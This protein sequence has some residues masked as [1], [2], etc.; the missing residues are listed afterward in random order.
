MLQSALAKYVSKS[1]SSG[2]SDEAIDLVC[3]GWV[4]AHLICGAACFTCGLQLRSIPFV[5]RFAKCLK[6]RLPLLILREEQSHFDF[7]C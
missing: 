6:I 2:C 4:S 5:N 1:I 3:F 7:G